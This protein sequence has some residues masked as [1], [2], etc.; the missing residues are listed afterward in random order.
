MNPGFPHDDDRYHESISSPEGK[1]FNICLIYSSSILFFLFFS[2]LVTSIGFSVK[3]PITSYHFLITVPFTLAF[4]I[5]SCFLFPWRSTLFKTLITLSL[6]VSSFFLSLDI[7]KHF[8]DISYDGQ[9]YHQEALIQLNRGWN[10]F[11]EQL[12]SWEANHMDRWLNTYSKGVWIYEA[13]I[14][15]VTNDIESAKLFHIWLMI[16]AFFFTLSFLS[17]FDKLPFILIFLISVLVAFNP[18]SIYQSL[19]FYLDGQLMSLMVILIVI[20]GLIYMESKHYYYILIVMT[21]AVLV[22]VKLTAGIYTLIIM[23]GYMVILWMKNKL[24]QLRKVFIFASA[25]FIIGFLLLGWNPYITNTIYRGNPLY[26][27][28]GTDRSDYTVPQFPA[29]FS[30]K[31]SVFLLF[32]SIFSRSDNVRGAD[33]AAYLKIPFTVSKDELKAFTDTNAKQGGFGPLFG[34]SILL[35]FL[36]IL[37]ALVT[38]WRGVRWP[39][40]NKN[41]KE[42]QQGGEYDETLTT[43]GMP[44]FCLA[45]IL[46]TCLINP[47]SSLAR[48]IPQMWLFP[49][50]AFFLACHSNYKSIRI[51]GYLIVF[52]LL[53]NNILIGIT[54]YKYNLAITNL[55]NSRLEKMAGASKQDPIKFY[56]GG[57]KSSNTT[58]FDKFGINYEII[59]NKEDCNN[60]QRILPHSIILKCTSK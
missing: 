48:F 30:G 36:I 24:F 51:F 15:K 49:I 6:L 52:A 40:Y 59:E 53:F 60:G 39:Q 7:S 38:L 19:S 43:I 11:Y 22:N 26:P 50:F 9:G 5:I 27:A 28:L 45:V 18:I 4:V 25:A 31:N 8:F 17:R 58:R 55:Y 3:I 41:L 23:S 1:V 56:F 33:K 35:S 13:I 2:I 21:I 34:G 29:N 37:W 44:L 57:F 32:Y 47:A 10:P 46:V 54:Y 20:L 16:A 42:R 12:R 14:F